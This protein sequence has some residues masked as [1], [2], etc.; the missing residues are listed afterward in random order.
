MAHSFTTKIGDNKYDDDKPTIKDAM[1]NVFDDRDT[2]VD[3]VS[4]DVN[5][6]KLTTIKTPNKHIKQYS[7]TFRPHNNIKQTLRYCHC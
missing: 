3:N 7:L 6:L 1:I 2:N 5:T 4:T